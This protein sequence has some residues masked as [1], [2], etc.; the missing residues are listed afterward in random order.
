MTPKKLVSVLLGCAATAA[1]MLTP[2]TGAA[3]AAI[4]RDSVRCSKPS[5]QWANFSWGE[6]NTSATIYFNNHCSHRV[7][8]RITFVRKGSVGDKAAKY[9]CMTVNA[10]TK[11]RKKF[12][13]AVYEPYSVTRV[14]H[15]G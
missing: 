9:R 8:V 7:S 2:A 15:C 3:A 4:E 14:S 1:V 5:G 13:A 11:G 10:H 6:G 12:Y